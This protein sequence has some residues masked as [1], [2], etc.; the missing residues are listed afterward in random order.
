MNLTKH[1]LY[2]HVRPEVRGLLIRLNL[3]VI[4][5]ISG[6]PGFGW[7]VPLPLRLPVGSA[8][9][10]ISFSRSFFFKLFVF[11]SIFF[12]SAH[13]PR[14]HRLQRRLFS[15]TPRHRHRRIRGVLPLSCA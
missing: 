10:R 6:S 11:C 14:V 3:T 1:T 15:E 4:K 8:S 5:L 2:T 13:F 9:Y 7:L 12:R